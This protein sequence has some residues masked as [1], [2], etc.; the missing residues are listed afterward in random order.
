V[1]AWVAQVQLDDSVVGPLSPVPAGVGE[2]DDMGG[3]KELSAGVVL[4]GVEGA[5]LE[6]LS[7]GVQVVSVLSGSPGDV[8]DADWGP[9]VLVGVSHVLDPSRELCGTPHGHEVSSQT[10]LARV[11]SSVSHP[12]DV[13]VISL[14]IQL[15]Q[16]MGLPGTGNEV[17]VS[18]HPAQAAKS[19]VTKCCVGTGAYRR[20]QVLE[21]GHGLD[22]VVLDGVDHVVK[23]GTTLLA[24]ASSFAKLKGS[25]DAGVVLLA[26][27]DSLRLGAV[28]WLEV[29][30]SEDGVQVLQCAE[31]HGLG[32]LH[33]ALPVDSSSSGGALD[34]E[35]K[36]FDV[37]REL[38]VKGV[39]RGDS[40]VLVGEVQS[41]AIVARRHDCCCWNERNGRAV[42]FML[43]AVTAGSGFGRRPRP[44][45]LNSNLPRAGIRRGMTAWRYSN[46]PARGKP[47]RSFP[48]PSITL[49]KPRHVTRVEDASSRHVFASM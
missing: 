25:S 19:E 9:V 4:G 39:S 6:L 23:S 36:V 21:V 49:G 10:G 27:G 37:L 2:E 7:H 47:C 12:D 41:E 45:K 16:D 35:D 1:P 42:V 46:F 15:L 44:P 34:L 5:V 32:Q 11:A 3:I 43:A 20:V 33:V 14:S 29:S 18:W 17:G 24:L 30:S 38:D 31:A 8:K 13:P 22:R 28:A 26:V 40:G 48:R